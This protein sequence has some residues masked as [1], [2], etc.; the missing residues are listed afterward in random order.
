VSGDD[1][2]QAAAAVRRV[3]FPG[4]SS[5]V[6]LADAED[7]L[8]VAVATTLAGILG[9]PVVQVNRLLP[10]QDTLS[11]LR[12]MRARSAKLV[13][14]SVLSSVDLLLA[15]NGVAVERVGSSPDAPTLSAQVA[16]WAI[17]RAGA[18]PGS[19]CITTAGTSR[20]AAGLAAGLGSSK[21]WPLV[22]GA[23]AARSAGG[24]TFLVGPEAAALS[25]EVPAPTAFASSSLFDLANEIARFAHSSVPVPGPVAVVPEGARTV[26]EVAGMGAPVLMYRSGS[27]NGVREWLIE[28]TS[29]HGLPTHAVLAE[30]AS[31]SIGPSGL[32]ELQS[33]VNGFAVHKLVGVGGQGLPIIE[34]PPEERPLGLARVGPAPGRRRR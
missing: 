24:P 9:V 17:G 27:L 8:I 15:L 30:G 12:E 25:A 31:G 34:Q 5:T 2:I 13:G 18:S 16:Q 33:L 19:V 21:R 20:A 26:T 3:K 14:P 11:G 1:R 22:V 4:G 7:G 29:A 32:Y 28:R 6:V 23:G 10:G